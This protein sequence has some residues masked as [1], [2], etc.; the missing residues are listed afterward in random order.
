MNKA[1]ALAIL[2]FELGS[3][4]IER[5]EFTDKDN[6][7]EKDSVR[8]STEMVKCKSDSNNES[9]ILVK[10]HITFRE[11][12]INNVLAINLV[13]Y[14]R[15]G[16]TTFYN[17]GIEIIGESLNQPPTDNFYSKKGNQNPTIN[18]SLVRTDKANDIWTD[19]N[20]IEY[21]KTK[22]GDYDR[23]TPKPEIQCNDKPL[24]QIMN[25]GDRNNCHWRTLNMPHLW[26]Y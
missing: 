4:E 2:H 14:A 25:G 12:P 22:Y 13:D 7:I 1:E 19:Q 16:Y 24:D 5:V 11:A 26:A 8:T 21:Q 10:M 15:N 17:D 9:C 6:L 23:I 3:T 18:H 20:G